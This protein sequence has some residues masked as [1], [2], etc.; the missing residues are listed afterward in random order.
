MFEGGGF[1]KPP[2]LLHSQGYTAPNEQRITA[3]IGSRLESRTGLPAGAVQKILASR[4]YLY[5][6]EVGLG[7]FTWSRHPFICFS[8]FSGK[9]TSIGLFIAKK[10]INLS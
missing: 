10:T 1:C 6:T 3:K 7:I 2:K 5:R 4:L 9:I 8:S